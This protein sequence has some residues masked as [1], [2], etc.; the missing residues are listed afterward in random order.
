MIVF[1]GF[2]PVNEVLALSVGQQCGLCDGIKQGDANCD[3]IIDL[4]DFTIW[5]SE[6]ISGNGRKT[7]FNCDKI[8]DL[9]DF[10][11]WKKSYLSMVGTLLSPTATAAP[12]PGEYMPTATPAPP[13][14]NY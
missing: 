13:P 7:D 9:A 4:V 10:T 11:I 1:F 2:F 6:Y 14:P 5:K 3:K 12:P 8:V